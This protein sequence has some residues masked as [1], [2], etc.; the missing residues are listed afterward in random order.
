MTTTGEILH[1]VD[2]EVNFDY[3]NVSIEYNSALRRME[4]ELDSCYGEGTLLATF[5]LDEE[6]HEFFY[7][8]IPVTFYRLKEVYKELLEDAKS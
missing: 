3:F 7:D 2:Y 6:R 8:G 1:F 4:Y 5:S